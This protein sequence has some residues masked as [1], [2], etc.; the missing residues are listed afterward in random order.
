MIRPTGKMAFRLSVSLFSQ[1]F[2][3]LN[4][5]QIRLMEEVCII[6]D[7]NDAVLRPG[8]KKET[9]L[10]ENIEKG[11]LHRAFSVF[12]FDS[13]DRLLLQRR[14]ADK[15][16]FPLCWTNTCCSHPLFIDNELDGVKG[17]K[18]AAVRKLEHELG[19]TDIK[20]ED[21]HYLN[22]IHYKAPYNEMWGEH[23]V[24]YILFAKKDVKLNLN[25]NEVESVEYIEKSKLLSK[26]DE[27]E[28]SGISISPWFKL[29]N[30]HFLMN[31][32]DNLDKII[33]NDFHCDTKIHRL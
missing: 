10:M 14:S 28:K 18:N 30:K 29:L 13:K 22:R 25:F 4:S 24:D 26:L 16:T 11:L 23:E 12:L 20:I 21:L 5:E 2:S 19:I 15:I 9:H 3:K 27:Y 6:V 31:W 8:S 32:W 1:M 7:K 17:V 33:L